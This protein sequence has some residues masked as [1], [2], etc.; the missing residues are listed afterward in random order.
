[1][2]SQQEDGQME[3]TTTTTTTT[4]TSGCEPLR[5][6][7]FEEEVPGVG[8]I[9]V[10]QCIDYD[11]AAQSTK[12]NDL[13]YEF[14]KALVCHVV[15]CLDAGIEPLKHLPPA[16]NHYEELFKMGEP[17]SPRIPR[18]VSSRDIPMMLRGTNKE[19]RV[20]A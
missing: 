20:A 14:E 7:M 1:M 12:L 6:V 18:V 3:P 16:P 17:Y 9:W 13:A 2:T 11:L 4:I 15:A 10:A 19:I 5:I 8:R